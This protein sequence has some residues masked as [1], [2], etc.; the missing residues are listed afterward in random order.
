MHQDSKDSVHCTLPKPG[1]DS[2][3]M[4]QQIQQQENNQYQCVPEINELLWRTAGKAGFQKSLTRGV[5]F[6]KRGFAQILL[7]KIKIGLITILKM[8]QKVPKKY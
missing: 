1:A 8:T 4:S 2:R 3:C 7:S 5:Y 6:L